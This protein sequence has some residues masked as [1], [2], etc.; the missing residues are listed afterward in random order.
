[1]F[2]VS[3][4]CPPPEVNLSLKH[5]LSESDIVYTTNRS[6]NLRTDKVINNCSA[7]NQI[8]Y[9]WMFSRVDSE[10]GFFTPFLMYG[11]TDRT[12]IKLKPRLLGAGVLYVSLEASVSEVTGASA[13]DYGFL[14]VRH[15]D[16]VA[17][18]VAPGSISK[19]DSKVKLDSSGSYDPEFKWLQYRKLNFSWQCQ[20]QC[21]WDS[22]DILTDSRAEREPCYGI[23]NATDS[24]ISNQRVLIIDVDFLRSSCIYLFHLSVAKGSR[25]THKEHALEV[26]PAVPFDIR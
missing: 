21:R 14:R 7:L 1:M 12:T 11:F 17:K 9:Q 25:I 10:T 13:Y 19:G 23:A 3:C 6:L 16:L 24:V 5:S 22:L 15:P 4:D 8:E 26:M 18:I 2:S 20:R